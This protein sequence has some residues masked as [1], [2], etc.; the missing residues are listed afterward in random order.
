MTRRLAREEGIFAGISSGGALWA[1][2]E[3]SKD[4][5]ERRH[6]LHR[7]RPRRPLSF[8]GRFP[9][10]IAA[11]GRCL[12]RRAIAAAA[13]AASRAS[14]ACRTRELTLSDRR[15]RRRRVLRAQSVRAS[16]PAPSFASSPST[17][18]SSTRRRAHVA[19][20]E[21][22]VR[23][24]RDSARRASPARAACSTPARR[25]RIAFSYLTA[26]ARAR[27]SSSSPAPTRRWRIAGRFDGKTP[28][29]RGDGSTRRALERLAPW[30]PAGVPKITAGRASGTITTAGRCT[31]SAP[32]PR[33]RS[34]SRTRADCTPAR[35]SRRRSKPMRA[36]R[37]TSGA[38]TRA[39]TWRGGEVFWQPFFIARQGPAA[40]ARRRRRRAAR[41]EVRSGR[42]RAA[43][44]SATSLSAARWDHAKG[45]LAALRG[46]RR[47]GV[48]VGALY[49]R[50][51]EAAA[52]R[53]P[54]C[55]TCARRAKLSVQRQRRRAAR[56]PPLELELQRRLVRRP[57]A[58]ASRC[59]A[60]SGRVPWRARASDHG[61][62]R[63]SK[64]PNS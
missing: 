64:A 29:H 36:A 63:R 25:F 10:V 39:L 62:A 47:R 52:C 5:R 12:R 21:A 18:T 22:H 34:R 37:A 6:R 23:G 7:L 28:A 30:L 24:R 16:S 38:G 54:R 53:G 1:A 3:V 20:G 35:R 58:R 8:H 26:R 46:E 43:R 9:C 50:P 51:A 40:R 2:L 56:S 31:D 27:C 14:G 13:A 33:R 44:A 19:Q 59:S 45:A 32:R 55:P 48:H 4:S 41:T 15:S 61:R 57:P 60:L 42:A 49:E 11:C 17:S